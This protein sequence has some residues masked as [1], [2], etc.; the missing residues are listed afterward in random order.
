MDKG[1]EFEGSLEALCKKKGIKT[2]STESEKKSAFTERNI[3]SLKNLIYKYLEDKWTY[4]Y[5]DKLQ[6]FVNAINSRTNRVTNLAL[7]K[8]TIKDVPRLILL[9]AEQSLKLVRRPKF[10]VGDY[11]RLADEVFEVF[12]IRTGN[13]PTFNLIDSNREP[14]EEKFYKSEL[15]RVLEKEK[16]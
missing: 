4:S 14:I 7:N 5:N 6:D 3:C 15:I 16:S 12:D 1:T 9:G 10:C 11:V 13:P 2:Y 8:V